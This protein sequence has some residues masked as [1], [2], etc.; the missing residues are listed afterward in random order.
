M[1]LVLHRMQ[2]F[3]KKIWSAGKKSELSKSSRVLCETPSDMEWNPG[4]TRLLYMS[5]FSTN[6]F[7]FLNYWQGFH[8]EKEGNFIFCGN[9]EKGT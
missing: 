2:L 9:E 8:S 1:H 5:D 6:A 4:H 3:T 7:M